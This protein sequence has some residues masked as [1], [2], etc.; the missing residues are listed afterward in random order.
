MPT[1][2]GYLFC[3]R[4]HACPVLSRGFFRRE[5]V[6]IVNDRLPELDLLLLRA[7]KYA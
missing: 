2:S 4:T 7:M 5:I 1:M 3:A 6:V